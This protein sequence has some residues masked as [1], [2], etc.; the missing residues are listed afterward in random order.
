MA[1]LPYCESLRIITKKKGQEFAIEGEIRAQDFF[2]KG[3]WDI[4]NVSVEYRFY[5]SDLPLDEGETIIILDNIKD[6][7]YK[8]LSRVTSV[9]RN[10][11]GSG[12][13]KFKWTLA[14]YCPIEYPPERN[15]LVEFFSVKNCT[16][17]KLWL[18]GV[19]LFR[20]VP[21]KTKILEKEIKE[22]GNI[23]L[24]YLIMTPYETVQ[25]EEMRGLQVRVRDV[26]IGFPRDF[27]VT[28]LGKV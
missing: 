17:M 7:I 5:D 28:K 23:K 2:T 3:N 26:A 10:I 24:K 8:E 6:Q 11:E 9:R 20:N 1:P 14:Q 4:S 21:E 13:E 15:D 19:Q 22:F 12:Y 16:P 27:D 18:D 25:P